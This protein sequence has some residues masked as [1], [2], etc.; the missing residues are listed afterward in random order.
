V[1]A[2]AS[3][4]QVAEGEGAEYGA[5][6]AADGA[7]ARD[8]GLGYHWRAVGAVHR[9]GHASVFP[10]RISNFPSGVRRTRP[11]SSACIHST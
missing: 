10:I 8:Y 4:F 11:S 9:I 5:P 3:I 1:A 6:T 2:P 7:S